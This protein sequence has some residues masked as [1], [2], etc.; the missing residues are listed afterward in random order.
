[1]ISVIRKKYP[2]PASIETVNVATTMPPCES[3]SVAVKGFGFDGG[4]NALNI[5][6]H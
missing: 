2:D 3:C 4:E 6:W 1:L 5:I